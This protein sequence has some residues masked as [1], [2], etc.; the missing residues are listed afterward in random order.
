VQRGQAVLV[1]LGQRGLLGLE[2]QQ[3]LG[4]VERGEQSL[5]HDVPLRVWS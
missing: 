3:A 1:E 2:H 4:L 5:V